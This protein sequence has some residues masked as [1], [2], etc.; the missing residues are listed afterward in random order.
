MTYRTG[1]LLTRRPLRTRTVVLSSNDGHRLCISQERCDASCCAA[2]GT[3]DLWTLGLLA[4]KVGLYEGRG[5]ILISGR[6]L[7]SSTN[8]RPLAYGGRLFST[9]C[10]S[11]ADDVDGGCER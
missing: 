4:V 2:Y 11:G 5:P 10:S 8:A 6:G 9:L 7:V 3:T 1:R